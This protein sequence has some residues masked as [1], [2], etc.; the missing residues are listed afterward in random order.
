[1]K[2]LVRFSNHQRNVLSA[3]ESGLTTELRRL[4]SCKPTR[5]GHRKYLNAL[6]VI[7]RIYVYSSEIQLQRG[8]EQLPSWHA[9]VCIED[10]P[11]SVAE[12]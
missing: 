11:G 1:M 4:L 10:Q 2:I 7:M 5:V 8:S 6:S 9:M 3:W 12:E